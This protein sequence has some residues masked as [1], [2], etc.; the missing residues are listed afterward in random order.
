MHDTIVFMVIIHHLIESISENVTLK[1]IS[2]IYACVCM[3]A[4]MYVHMY[5]SSEFF[6]RKCFIDN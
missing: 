3:Y 1:Y 5:L 6:D 4:Y 2:I